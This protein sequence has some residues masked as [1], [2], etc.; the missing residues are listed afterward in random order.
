MGQVI[1]R[2]TT[3]VIGVINLLTKGHSDT[4]GPS[5]QLMELQDET[6]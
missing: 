4:E 1:I 5:V 2:V 6:D 3:W